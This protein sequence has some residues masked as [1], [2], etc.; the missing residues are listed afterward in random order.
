[1]NINYTEKELHEN[2]NEKELNEFR[3][4]LFWTIEGYKYFYLKNA[5]SIQG[6]EEALDLANATARVLE[7]F[8]NEVLLPEEREN[9]KLI[10]STDTVDE[11]I[12]NIERLFMNSYRLSSTNNLNKASMREYMKFYQATDEDFE[13][14][15]E[16]NSYSK[17]I[18][19][20]GAVGMHKDEIV[21]LS[22]RPLTVSR[23]YA[24]NEED[25]ITDILDRKKAVLYAKDV[26]ERE[27]RR[28]NKS[29]DYLCDYQI[30][31]NNEY[32]NQEY[33]FVD[34]FTQEKVYK[35]RI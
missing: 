7:Y 20:A 6:D 35:P 19:A 11:D 33:Y 12:K 28:L 27:K 18:L 14:V 17:I 9:F 13:Y 32:L 4:L 21:R 16:Y 29:L 26:S 5:N 31:I 22:E 24:C 15:D 30:M 23:D 2:V 3:D 10:Q 34:D 1:M 8:S 25:I